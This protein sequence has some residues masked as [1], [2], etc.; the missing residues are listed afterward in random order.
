MRPRYNAISVVYSEASSYTIFKSL[1]TGEI[2]GNSLILSRSR[3]FAS[4]HSQAKSYAS[5][6]SDTDGGTAELH[7][8]E[9]LYTPEL[10]AENADAS[11]QPRIQSTE[12]SDIEMA[13]I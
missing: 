3:T 6:A 8:S 1:F 9:D 7:G 13:G 4:R 5:R 10:Q 12:Q 2:E 11:Q